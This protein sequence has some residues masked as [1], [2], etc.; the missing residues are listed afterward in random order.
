MEHVNTTNATRQQQQLQQ[1][2]LEQ[3]QQHN[4]NQQQFCL[5]WHNH[6]TSLLSTLPVLLDQ[7]H[8]TDVTISAE[9]RLLRAHRV[10]LSACSSFFM[11]IFRAL[12]ASNHP[13]IIIPGASFAAIVALLTFMYSGEVNVYEEQIPMLLNLAETLGIKGLADVQNNNL[14]KTTKN[15]PS[16]APA[17]YMDTPSIDKPLSFEA[18]RSPSPTPIPTPT[19]TPNLSIPQL[20]NPSLQAPLLANK[21]GTP[22]ENFFL[23]SLQFYPNLLPQ[24]LNFSQTALNKTTELLAKY[25]QQCQL[26]Q[27]SLEDED[28]YGAKRLKNTSNSNA[29]NQQSGNLT[30]QQP[31]KDV[32]RIDKIVENLRTTS[33]NKSPI[34]CGAPNSMVATSPVAL[35]PQSMSHFS[36]Q[37]PVV[38]SSPSSYSNPMSAGQL[39]SSAKLPSYSAAATPTTAQ[40]AS[41]QVATHH[42]NTPYISPEDHAKLQQHIE[43]YAACQREAAAAAAAGQMVSA[44]SEPNLLSL[45][46]EKL[47][48]ASKPPSNSK[49][50]ATCFICHKQLSNQYNL[51]VHLE[52]HQNVR[53]ACNVCSHVS[54][55]KDALRKHVSYR[56][57]GAPSPCENE[58][59]RK[60]VT[61]LA[62]QS[63]LA[64]GVAVGAAASTPTATA[65]SG[66]VPTNETGP[67]SA[68]S[69]LTSN[70]YLFLPNQFQLAAAAAAVAVAESNTTPALDLAHELPMLPIKSSPP[71]ASNGEAGSGETGTSAT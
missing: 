37:L 59:R 34:E 12:E 50:Y 20:P 49:L 42:A 10:V 24:P 51:R 18:T 21:L 15:A 2:Q 58:A 3:Q 32:K 54:R 28:C 46:A 14:P 9:G 40:Q 68:P 22:L 71:P 69:T 48:T 39:Y 38:K 26:Y 16:T 66:D 25:Q 44:K 1:L 47:P 65:T 57:P 5:R 62:A 60:R 27:N 4:E 70:P 55:S 63:T 64:T 8:L 33:N 67:S 31:P 11:E 30:A 7:S 23:K 19:T 29:G 43:Q 6:Q 36:P 41:H 13:V 52:T 53:Y 35:A 17:S 56:H 61:K 45:T